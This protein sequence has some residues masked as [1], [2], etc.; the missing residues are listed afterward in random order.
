MYP[1]CAQSRGTI[2]L[3]DRQTAAACKGEGKPG[4]H[5]SWPSSS[6]GLL[7]GICFPCPLS[8]PGRSVSYYSLGARRHTTKEQFVACLSALN[9][10]VQLPDLDTMS[11]AVGRRRGVTYNV[12]PRGLKKNR[13]IRAVEHDGHIGSIKVELCSPKIV[14]RVRLWS[15]QQPPTIDEHRLELFDIIMWK[16]QLS[17]RWLRMPSARVVLDPDLDKVSA[18]HAKATSKR[19]ERAYQ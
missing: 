13:M 16:L 19:G 11:L 3:D 4:S 8:K 12:A 9:Q 6:F 14:S 15:L 18:E 1:Q 10:P 17:P 7:V 5:S 2:S